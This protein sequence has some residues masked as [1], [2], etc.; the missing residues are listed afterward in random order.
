M[1]QVMAVQHLA[2]I[3]EPNCFNQRPIHLACFWPEGLDYL[4][5]TEGPSDVN[6]EATRFWPLIRYAAFFSGQLCPTGCYDDCI[7]TETLEILFR[8]DKVMLTIDRIPDIWKVASRKAKLL[9]LEQ[10]ADR[11]RRLKTLAL[12][13]LSS[14]EAEEVGLLEDSLLDTKAP[15]VQQRLEQLG[16]HIPIP[17]CTMHR[18]EIPE[19][20][21]NL[22]FGVL[23]LDHDRETAEHAFALGFRDVD[24]FRPIG[25]MPMH[26][27]NKIF[28]SLSDGR[29]DVWPFAYHA[30]LLDHGVSLSLVLV[31]AAKESDE[32]DPDV[33]TTLAHSEANLIGTFVSHFESDYSRDMADPALFRVATAV[34]GAS[35][36]DRCQC[37][38]LVN[39]G[40]TP[41]SVALK[42][43]IPPGNWRSSAR[44][45][46]SVNRLVH[47]WR[48]L[49][50]ETTRAL[51][52]QVIR[53]MTFEA[54]ALE[55][56]CCN[57]S[58]GA[59]FNYKPEDWAG[60]DMNSIHERFYPD[61]RTV[62][63]VWKENALR[64]DVL[65]GL[66]G[67]LEGQWRDHDGGLLEFL[68]KH[69]EPTIAGA[70]LLQQEAE[71]RLSWRERPS[72]VPQWEWLA[73]HDVRQHCGPGAATEREFLARIGMKVEKEKCDHRQPWLDF[74]DSLDTINNTASSISSS[75][76]LPIATATTTTTTL[77]T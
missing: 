10:L 70:I 32:W 29:P 17:L 28:D 9:L 34:F 47:L 65:E 23:F 69:W 37:R 64:I 52:L 16:V 43:M 5:Q 39:S 63:T 44:W 45:C 26:G 40:C 60:V 49:S 61:T 42:Q 22:P 58:L 7:C 46:L 48:G 27:T 20:S 57:T 51:S 74:G 62:Q 71:A 13:A 76:P 25:G 31:E 53:F 72:G 15:Y 19:A 6:I 77:R 38:C 24:R 4:I 66:M 68:Q 3:E 30:W 67:N 59:R 35:V 33:A 56:T 73:V 55:H 21:G 14:A 11:R 1:S 18:P 41:I 54:L 36:A 12:S 50:T 75:S 8:T 2:E